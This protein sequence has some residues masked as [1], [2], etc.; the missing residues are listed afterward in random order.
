MGEVSVKA[1]VAVYQLSGE[2]TIDIVR[3]FGSDVWLVLSFS[4]AE[5]LESDGLRK[6]QFLG[7]G[8]KFEFR[9]AAVQ[10][11]VKSAIKILFKNNLHKL[12]F[13]LPWTQNLRLNRS[14]SYVLH[15]SRYVLNTPFSIA[16][17]EF[18]FDH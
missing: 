15:V 9:Y 12:W 5:Q 10:N 17:I 16:K 2:L 3:L 18:S 6:I 14:V 11:Q 8:T 4:V 7:L 13:R 1:V